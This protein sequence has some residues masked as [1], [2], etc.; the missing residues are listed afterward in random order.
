MVGRAAWRRVGVAGQAVIPTPTA[1][2]ISTSVAT[3]GGAASAGAVGA[4]PAGREVIVRNR[5]DNPDTP[6]TAAVVTTV[7]LVAQDGVRCFEWRTGAE[8]GAVGFRLFRL[9]AGGNLSI[10]VSDSWVPALGN[11]AG[12]VYRV[13]EPAPAGGSAPC[14]RIEELDTSGRTWV[15]GPFETQAGAPESCA[16]LAVRVGVAA[17]AESVP[18]DAGRTARATARREEVRTATTATAAQRRGERSTTM[19]KLV[20]D[21]AGTYAVPVTAIAPAL[22]LTLDEAREAVRSGGVAP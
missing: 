5:L 18:V 8:A 22:D 10:G 11:P 17:W 16:R 20:I 19:L 15:Y 4:S 1:D 3:A 6:P 12:G 13:A 2:V 7:R 9:E 14:Y 21:K